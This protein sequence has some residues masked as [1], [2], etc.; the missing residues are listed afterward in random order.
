MKQKFID[1][2][3]F[4]TLLRKWDAVTVSMVAATFG[5]FLIRE[6][7]VLNNAETYD[8]VSEIFTS[9]WFGIAFIIIGVVKIVS[10]WFNIT[11]LKILSISLLV[12]LWTLFGV[13]LILN[14]TVNSI[15]IHCFGWALISF[16]V[17]IREWI[18]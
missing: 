6:P 5:M 4:R 15:Y 11:W 14:D 2:L 1:S 17:S 12:G 18:I 16:G 8:I 3:F 7:Q 10:I 9:Y 13:S